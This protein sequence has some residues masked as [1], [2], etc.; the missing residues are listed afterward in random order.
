MAALVT[1]EPVLSFVSILNSCG[2]NFLKVSGIHSFEAVLMVC[3][4]HAKAYFNFIFNS[5]CLCGVRALEC[6][7]HRKTEE[8]ARSPGMI[9]IQHGD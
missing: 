9:V 5:V 7:T 3:F 6:S 1:R 4:Y 2:E 8:G